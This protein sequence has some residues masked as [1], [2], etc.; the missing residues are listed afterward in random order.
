[1]GSARINLEALN[2]A[3]IRVGET[4]IDP[5]IWPQVMEH[6]CASVGAIGAALLQGDARTLDI[7]RTES[8]REGFERY[9]KEGWHERD[10]RARAI[11]LMLRGQSVVTDQDIV[12][13]AE[14]QEGSYY[15]ECIYAAGLKWWA[16]V[17]FLAGPS[18][19][20]LC[21]Q[22]TPEE[23]PFEADEK[24]ALS[25]LSSKLTAAATLSTIVGRNTLS[26]TIEG[27]ALVDQPALVLDRNGLVLGTNR[28]AEDI[29][30]DDILI[31]CRRLHLRDK[32]ANSKLQ[33]L[34][35]QLAAAPDTSNI[36]I[37]P[38]VV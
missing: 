11:P 13:P 14:M 7:P 29:F 15:N 20:A 27:L 26:A 37:E 6:I 8:V 4:V 23:G 12:T 3:S 9:F 33:S 1:M 22:R 19:W 30:D 35:E 32:V 24:K 10:L 21:I 31:K 2:Q 38:F 36:T 5:A 17:A 18:L 34:I 28:T 16:G 25:Q